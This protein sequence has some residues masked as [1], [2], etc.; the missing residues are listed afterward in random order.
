MNENSLNPNLTKCTLVILNGDIWTGDKNN[1]KAEAVAISEDVIV[2]VGSN[3]DIKSFLHP[4]IEIIDAKGQFICPGFI[5]CHIHMI[6]GGERL[7]SVNL[8]PA[9]TQKEFISYIGEFA[10]SKKKGDWITGGDWDHINWGG[11]LPTRF[12]IDSVTQD[13]PV[14]IGRYEGHTYLANTLALKIAGLLEGKVELIE[15]GTVECDE[16]GQMTGIFKDNAL[17]LVFK[18]VP[19]ASTE[20]NT[21]FMELAMDYVIS[22]GVTSVHNMIEP[23]DRNR[24]GTAKDAE[25]GN[26]EEIEGKLRTRI[27]VATPIQFAKNLSEKLKSRPNSKLL[28]FGSLKGYID[29]SLGSHSCLMFEPFE[30]TPNYSGD[31]VNT[32]EDLYKWAKEADE[33]GQQVFLHAIGDKGIHEV[34][35][36]FERIVKENGQKDRRWRIEHSQHLKDKDI[37][38]FAELGV[39]ASV[40][41]FHLI[42]DGRFIEKYLGKERLKNSFAFRSLIDA[43]AI[44]AFGSDWFVAPPNP[45]FT[46]HAAVNRTD[47]ENIFTP[48]EK[49]SVEEALIAHT[50]HAAYSV[51]EENT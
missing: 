34:L 19:A 30:N 42:Q 3:E 37:K 27:Y 4:E 15:G 20:E 50:L 8:R 9:R 26:I 22:H 23:L 43:G 5:D 47:G 46:I 48:E 18:A 1:P 7:N 12:M 38:R 17:K 41:P 6:M 10:K 44:L 40:Q 29:G 36:I 25:I 2:F 31:F 39:I 24:G 16:N 11:S 32:L 21:K 45:L 33:Y 14:W 28:R 35:N 13:N 51:H 49:I